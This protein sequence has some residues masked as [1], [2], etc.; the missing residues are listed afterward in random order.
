MSDIDRVSHHLTFSLRTLRNRASGAA[1]GAGFNAATL[2]SMDSWGLLNRTSPLPP[3]VHS[4]TTVTDNSN[5]V[6]DLLALFFQQH[7]SSV[8]FFDMY[9][10]I[11]DMN[12][13]R[14]NFCTPLLVN[15]VLAIGCTTAEGCNDNGNLLSTSSLAAS[16]YLE[17]RRH[18]QAQEGHDSITRIQGG[19]LLAYF[20]NMAGRDKIGLSFQDEAVRIAKALGLFSVDPPAHAMIPPNGVTADNWNHHRTV[21]AWMLFNWQA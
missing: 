2:H 8:H 7:H 20:C 18:W 16:F 3:F 15:A 5:L 13:N 10:F 11:E 12:N 1:V 6:A 19:V 14:T 17:A 4:W 21:T 9:L